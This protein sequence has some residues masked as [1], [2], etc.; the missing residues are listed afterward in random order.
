MITAN[1]TDNQIIQAM[2]IDCVGSADCIIYINIQNTVEFGLKIIPKLLHIEKLFYIYSIFCIMYTSKFS[3]AFKIFL[4]IAQK[5]FGQKSH[6]CDMASSH[7]MLDLS[8]ANL[9]Y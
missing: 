7:F 5:M 6:I 3:R 4:K 8:R 9:R 1:C 2:T